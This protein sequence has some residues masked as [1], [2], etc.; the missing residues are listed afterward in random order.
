MVDQTRRFVVLGGAAA[1]TATL[2][3]GTAAFADGLRLDELGETM[4][5]RVGSRLFDNTDPVRISST[6]WE[7][8]T[9]ADAFAEVWNELSSDPA[10]IRLAQEYQA[11]PEAER[12]LDLTT[13]SGRTRESVPDSINKMIDQAERTMDYLDRRRVSSERMIDRSLAY[14]EVHDR[15]IQALLIL[16][17]D[18]I[19]GTDR[20]IDSMNAEFA[21]ALGQIQAR[22]C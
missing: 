20:N 8:Q 4:V 10:I 7:P 12:F 6:N 17:A 1:A 15:G 11:N 5:E 9:I 18:D 13:S 2:A 19:G 22:A 21:E 14:R 16:N 3:M